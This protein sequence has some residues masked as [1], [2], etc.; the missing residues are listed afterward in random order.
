M[1]RL[2]TAERAQIIRLLVEGSSLR[3]ITRVV[4]HAEGDHCAS[5]RACRMAAT[6]RFPR[7]WVFM[8]LWV[9][10]GRLAPL[11]APQA[12]VAILC[13][14]IIRGGLTQASGRL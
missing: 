9:P 11:W 12:N 10:A 2:S 5:P 14:T 8:P 6:P 1:N 3:S 4:D 13:R 7:G